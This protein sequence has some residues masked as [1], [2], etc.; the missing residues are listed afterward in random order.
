MA[1][2]AKPLEVPPELPAAGVPRDAAQRLA[3]LEAASARSAR[4]SSEDPGHSLL[5]ILKR[6][7]T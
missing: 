6:F 7:Q 1:P 4:P 3:A 5:I 2:P